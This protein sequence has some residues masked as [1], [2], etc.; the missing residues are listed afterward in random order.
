MHLSSLAEETLSSSVRNQTQILRKSV[1]L[2]DSSLESKSEHLAPRLC[3]LLLAPLEH[4]HRGGGA[5][6]SIHGRC[7]AKGDRQFS[8]PLV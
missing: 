8:V 6:Y 3:A 5:A 7:E 4:K 2:T 1:Y